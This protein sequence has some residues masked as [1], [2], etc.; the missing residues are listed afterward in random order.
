[1]SSEVGMR[2]L[3]P[4][5]P[6]VVALGVLAAACSS[7]VVSVHPLTTAP[8]T[9]SA[10]VQTRFRKAIVR[11]EDVQAAAKY[12]AELSQRYNVPPPP[13]TPWFTVLQGNS[14]VL[15]V[16]GHAT[17]HTREGSLKPADGGTGSLAMILNRLARTTAIHT[18]YASPSDPNYY[19][20]NDFKRMVKLLVEERHPG[21]VLDLHASHPDHPYDVDFGTMEGRS[22][23]G[24]MR[25]LERLAV[26]LRDEGLVNFSHDFFGASKNQTIT[27]WVSGLGVATIQCE[28]NSTWL[29]PTPD[30]VQGRDGGEAVDKDRNGAATFRPANEW[31]NALQYQHFAELLQ[32]FVRYIAEIDAAP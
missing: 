30:K 12:E 15:V 19:D 27:K 29:I 17:A 9:N 26:S 10:V 13:G 28:I 16:A 22:L 18:T 24:H 1:M 21:I 3:L 23:L 14:R 4:S 11:V 8:E 6:L 20:D 5:P 2:V 32:G 25:L 31:T 7:P